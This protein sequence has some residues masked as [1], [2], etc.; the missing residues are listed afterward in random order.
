MSEDEARAELPFRISDEG[1]KYVRLQYS[2]CPQSVGE[3]TVRRSLNFDE[4]HP[5]VAYVDHHLQNG[6]MVRFKGNW[7][8][9]SGNMHECVLVFAEKEVVCIPISGSVLHLKK[10]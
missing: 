3:K 4:D 2:F 5:T 8:Q 1:D 6:D 10:D 7:N 9:K